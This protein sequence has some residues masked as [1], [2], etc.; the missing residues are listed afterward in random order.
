M[1]SSKNSPLTALTDRQK[2]VVGAAALTAG[3]ITAGLNMAF[4]KEPGAAL[5]EAAG[6]FATTLA[7][8]HGPGVL[9]DLGVPKD[10]TRPWQK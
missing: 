2:E 9:S 5:N 4:G 8:M 10:F 3:V 7:K 6:Q 1:F